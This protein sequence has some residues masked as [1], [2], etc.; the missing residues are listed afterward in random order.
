M[1]G[2]IASALCRGRWWLL[3]DFGDL[4]GQRCEVGREVG[5]EGIDVVAEL[6][7][8]P[9]QARGREELLRVVVGGEG[10][11]GACLGPR[12]PEAQLG[13]VGFGGGVSRQSRQLR[14]F[15]GPGAVGSAALLLRLQ[16]D[17]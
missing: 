9:V 3:Q 1:R 13:V 14:S 2:S 17:D 7:A 10:S 5:I 11:L 4:A 6:G 16:L 8:Q 15:L 12:V